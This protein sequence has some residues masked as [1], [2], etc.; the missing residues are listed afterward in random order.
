M[1][2]LIIK[3]PWITYILEGRKTWEIR[4]GNCRI[5]GRIGLVRSDSGLVVGTAKIAD[6]LGPLSDEKMRANI[7]RHCIPLR[8]LAAVRNRYKNIYAWVPANATP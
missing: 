5:R 8:D 6:S 4:G 2:G 7:S 3:E 1:Q